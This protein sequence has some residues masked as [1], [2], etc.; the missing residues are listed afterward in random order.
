MADFNFK[1]SL[2]EIK[3]GF[4]QGYNQLLSIIPER[5]SP[6][7]NLLIFS[8]L[9][10]VYGIF[11]WFF[12][13][14]LSKKDLIRLDLAQYNKTEHPGL[15]KFY[16]II[17][18]ILEYIVIL[19]VLIFFWFAFM[20]LIIIAISEGLETQH[21]MTITAA[22]VAAIR[23]ISYYH[24][25]MS[26]DL[27]KLFPLT[28]LVIFLVT[29]NF[30][31]LDRIFSFITEIPRFISNIIYFFLFIIAVE[32]ILRMIDLIADVFREKV[33]ERLKVR[34]ISVPKA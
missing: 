14:N 5:Y 12:Y 9:I 4:V 11:T 23:I 29:P 17:L 27:A 15:N 21:I 24:E 3:Q 22:I 32:L 26:R 31:S 10:S 13:K 7:F 30:F 18:Y 34:G 2:E 25:E 33:D 8:I 28:M 19:P 1:M 6:L 20:T 16:A